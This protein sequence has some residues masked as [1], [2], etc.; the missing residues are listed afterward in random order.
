MLTCYWTKRVLCGAMFLACPAAFAQGP[1]C[2]VSVPAL[3]VLSN[4]SLMRNM[5]ADDFVSLD[6]QRPVVVQ[7]VRTVVAPRRILFVVETG[8]H[9]KADVRAVEA[10]IISEMLKSARPG[11]SFALTTA[12]GPYV[13]VRFGA[14]RD[15]L[16]AAVN[17]IRSGLRAKSSEE[18]VLDAILRSVE[19]FLPA[20][21]GDAIVVLALGVEDAHKSSYGKVRKRLADAGIRVFGFQLGPYMA[22]YIQSNAAYSFG[23]YFIPTSTIAPN[24]ESLI[25]LS[26]YTGG[27]MATENAQGEGWTT[28]KLTDERLEKIRYMARQEAK[29][30]AEF[31]ELSLE[32][33][34]RDLAL[35][36]SPAVQQQ[37][38][39]AEAVYPRNSKL[40]SPASP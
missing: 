2:Q 1:K 15:V 16:K 39:Q 7:S 33:P 4:A 13:E 17:E 22:G 31:Y 6:K 34:V 24:R 11:D 18:G 5:K 35:A 10:E 3:V 29:A 37:F 20:Q 32:G 27:L 23:G 19:W 14:D 12:N 26:A 40:C 8:R 9:L 38:P 28:Y 21:E 30:I 25:H 36:V